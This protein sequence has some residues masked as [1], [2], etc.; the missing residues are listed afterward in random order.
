MS[1]LS[2]N[3]AP[4]CLYISSHPE[5]ITVV[6]NTI[7]HPND[8]T[9]LNSIRLLSNVNAHSK[10]PKEASQTFRWMVNTLVKLFKAGSP[11]NFTI[12][13]VLTDLVKMNKKL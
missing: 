13:Q 5:V 12:C 7:R 8:Q 3:H 2:Q 1:T 6:M 10:L 11:L 4:T 9:K